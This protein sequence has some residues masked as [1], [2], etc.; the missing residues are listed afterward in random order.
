MASVFFPSSTDRMTSAGPGRNRSRPKMSRSVRFIFVSSRV[1][2]G[3]RALMH[4]SLGSP[5]GT[6]GMWESLL[7]TVR[8]LN[9]GPHLRRLKRRN[10][11]ATTRRMTIDPGHTNQPRS[12]LY[13][14]TTT[15]PGNPIRMKTTETS[16]I[17]LKGVI[18]STPSFLNVCRSFS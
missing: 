2:F 18:S 13:P 10:R 3:T 1:T 6:S 8:V 11:A 7:V 5:V 9:V 15:Q 4:I 16:P 17:R 12:E 14:P